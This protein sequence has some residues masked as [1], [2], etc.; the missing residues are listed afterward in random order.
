MGG[1]GAGGWVIRIARL[2][3]MWRRR[4]A[5]RLGL[6]L[7]YALGKRCSAPLICYAVAAAAVLFGLQVSAVTLLM[8]YS[9]VSC[10]GMVRR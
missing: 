10:G 9:I 3:G 7:C 8:G 5:M 1:G 6:P 2:R 4:W